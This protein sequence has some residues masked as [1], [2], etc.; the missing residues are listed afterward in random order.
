MARLSLRVAAQCACTRLYS[1][2]VRAPGRERGVGACWRRVG[3]PSGAQVR[4][5][6]PNALRALSSGLRGE[7]GRG[8]IELVHPGEWGIIGQPVGGF[9]MNMYV[10]FCER[11]KVAAFIDTGATTEEELAPFVEFCTENEFEVTH[12]LQTH[13]HIDHVAGLGMAKERYPAATVHLHANDQLLYDT[14]Y[15]QS[16]F[17]GVPLD[18]SLPPVDQALSDGDTVAVGG[19]ELRVLHTPGHCAG[20]VCFVCDDSGFAFGGD[21]IFQGSIGRTDLPGSDPRLMETSVARVMAEL[22]DKVHVL[23]GHMGATTIGLERRSNPL[24]RQLCDAAAR[25]A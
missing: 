16:K 10:L 6:G 12:L 13:A 23:P 20:H 24:V 22:D 15:A 1:A 8:L 9:Q 3:A 21:L 18:H 7:P 11:A 17:F 5:Q 19:V 2:A 4:R 14:A 25:R